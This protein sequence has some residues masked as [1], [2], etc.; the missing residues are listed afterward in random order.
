[1]RC[2]AARAAAATI[3]SATSIHDFV[4]RRGRPRID[5]SGILAVDHLVIADVARG[6]VAEQDV[7]DAASPVVAH[8]NK[9]I[10]GRVWAGV[11]PARIDAIA[12]VVEAGVAGCGV[13]EQDIVR[14]VALEVAGPEQC[15][16]SRGGS[17]IDPGIVVARV[18]ETC[19]A[20]DGILKQDVV[21]A[22]AL[23][24]ADP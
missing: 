11:S 17:N 24:V 5:P 23:E 14:A 21:D 6:I 22:V 3:T 4:E 15:V 16:R 2:G 9:T 7:V 20:G 1:K 13:A 18:V 12:E 10:G 8:S 19:I